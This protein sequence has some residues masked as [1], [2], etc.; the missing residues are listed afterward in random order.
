MGLVVFLK[1]MSA[2]LRA[3]ARGS[4][5]VALERRSVALVVRILLAR[6]AVEGYGS[7]NGPGCRR[8]VALEGVLWHWLSDGLGAACF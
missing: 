3:A 2:R 8:R 6:R 4:D 5:S 1:D 7:I